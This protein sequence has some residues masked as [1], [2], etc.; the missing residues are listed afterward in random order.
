MQVSDDTAAQES[1]AAE[2]AAPAP[3]PAAPSAP[4][5]QGPN[6][7]TSSAPAGTGKAAASSKPAG[8]PGVRGAGPVAKPLRRRKN[9]AERFLGYV[10]QQLPKNEN[11][12]CAHC[13]ALVQSPWTYTK[14]MSMHAYRL[15]MSSHCSDIFEAH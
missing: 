10:Q 5:A 13:S 3:A 6:K 14:A 7:A 11:T 4:A 12:R 15:L 9:T 2:A 1:D 8:R